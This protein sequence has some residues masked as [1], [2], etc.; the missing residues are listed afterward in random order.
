MYI[1]FNLI[2]F[3]I[4]DNSLLNIYTL[5]C[6]IVFL[7]LFKFLYSKNITI[8]LI[9]LVLLLNITI[10]IL[11]N[12]T[13]LIS[14]FFSLEILNAA[15]IYSMLFFNNTVLTNN[16]TVS[17]GIISSCIYQLILNFFS[18]ILLFL[19]LNSFISITGSD[20]LIFLKLIQENTITHTL[21][22]L[23]FLF[24]LGTGP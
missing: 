3:L 13:S 15:I 17:I 19:G 11:F 21:L 7:L 24:K 23:G 1:I 10:I 18:S 22:A 2:I 16:Y 6:L 20:Q 12:S 5:I 8:D 4:P 14:I 9:V